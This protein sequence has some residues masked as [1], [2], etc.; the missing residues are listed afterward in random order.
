M[1]LETNKSIA[2]HAFSEIAMRFPSLRLHENH[3]DQVES[4][5]TIPIQ[6]GLKYAV[7]LCLQGGEELLFSVQNFRLEWVPCTNPEIVKHYVDAVTGFLA[8]RYPHSR[9]L[10]AGHLLQG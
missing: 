1:R 10:F 5:I 9:T 2:R 4:S 7:E 3:D 6:L 8:G